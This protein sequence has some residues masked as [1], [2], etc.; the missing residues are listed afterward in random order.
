MHLESP[1]HSAGAATRFALWNLG[2]RPFYL[3][4]SIFA[5]LSVLL[6]TL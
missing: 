5:A 6:W 1:S 3:L 4:A 2:F